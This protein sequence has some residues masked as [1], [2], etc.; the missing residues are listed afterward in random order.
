MQDADPAIGFLAMPP[1]SDE[2]QR[3]CDEDLADVGYVMNVSR[4][5]AYQPASPEGLFELMRQVTAPRP[6]TLRERGILVAAC[7]STYGDSYCSLGW[8]SKLAAQTDPDLAAGVLRGDTSALSAA[9]RALAEWAHAVAKDPNGTRPADLQALRAAGYSDADIFA[10]TA[11]IGLRIALSTVNDALG[12]RP[13]AEFRDE[14]PAAV[15]DAVTFGRPIDDA[16][17]IRRTGR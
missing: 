9:E 2:A 14:A 13:D 1:P 7:A 4:L 11:F 8:G 3:L 17:A 12:V 6:F 5:W 15:L 10:M 16:P